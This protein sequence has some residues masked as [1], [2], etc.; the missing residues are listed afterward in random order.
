M[1]HPVGARYADGAVAP[2]PTLPAWTARALSA[3]VVLLGLAAFVLPAL[4]HTVGWSGRTALPMHWPVLLAGLVYGWR[5]GLLVG[6]AA[7]IASHL[8]SGMPPVPV[9]PGMTMELAMYGLVAGAVRGQV[10]W[11]ASGPTSILSSLLVATLSA[12]IAGR[13]VY[14]VLA[15]AAGR[16]VDGAWVYVVSAFGPGAWAALGQLVALPLVAAWWVRRETSD[17]P[18][19][20]GNRS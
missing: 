7:P 2:F 19:G 14:L 10:R 6:L 16:V 1:S 15:L 18:T 9:L 5:A 3:Q 12:L 11:P 20:K 8:L 17:N 13:V 4:T